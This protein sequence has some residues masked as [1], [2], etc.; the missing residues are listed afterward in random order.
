MKIV[1]SGYGKMGREVE[2]LAVERG[3]IVVARPD[4][5][6]DWEAMEDQ[7]R[8]ADVVIDFSTPGSVVQNIRRCFDLGLPVVTGT[9]GWNEHQP[10]VRHWCESESQA[11]FTASN[12][13]I[14]V[15][16]LFGLTRQLATQLNRF[17]GY[18]IT[19]DETHHI[20]KLDAPSGTA[21][22][23]AGLILKNY[24]QKK[25]WVNR[26]SQEPEELQILSHREGEVPGTHIIR[27]QSQADELLL[28]H[29]AHNRKGLAQGA[30]MAA[31][32][33]IGKKGWF[34]MDDL[35][36]LPATV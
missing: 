16:I 13:S 19:I 33:L 2:T 11:I 9:T 30:M 10:Q 26:E 20:H 12:F 29:K 24:T 34:G 32:W 27:C 25:Q 36:E 14:G 35:L 3:H 6:S 18:D 31:E 28:T 1:L 23:L 8:G 15:N 21:I 7:I 5:P 17:G 22:H 4:N